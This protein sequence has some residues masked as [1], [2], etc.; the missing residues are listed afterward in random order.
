M[1]Y[2]EMLRKGNDQTAMRTGNNIRLR[3]DGRYEARYIKSRDE[4]D[5]IVYGYCYGNSYEEAEAKRNT[6]IHKLQP[7]RELNLLILGAGNHGQEVFELA[8][9][10]RIFHK[11]RFLDDIRTDIALGPCKDFAQYLDEFPVAIPAIGDTAVRVR[12]MNELVQ[13][14][15]VIPTLI[16]P[17][18]VVSG[19]A[20]IG[21][22]TVICARATVGT[23]A[24]IGRGCIISSGAT[25]DRNVQML[26]WSYADCGEII[27][28]QSIRKAASNM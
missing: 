26:D 22:G 20:Q 2:Y 23:N 10:L 3:K 24:V 17:S 18:A 13:A 12:W 4:Q 11:I 7:M 27:S 15:F 8:Q 28:A 9:S 5:R 14:G 25:I 1:P 16:H 21:N 6:Q 19:S